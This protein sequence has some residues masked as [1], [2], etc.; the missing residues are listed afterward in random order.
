M[1]AAAIVVAAFAAAIVVA[2][3]AAA[4]V[5]A[6]FAFAAAAAITRY[7]HRRDPPGWWGRRIGRT[8]WRRANLPA[9]G[10]LMVALALVFPAIAWLL[11]IAA[12][13]MSAA[14][15]AGRIVDPLPPL[16]ARRR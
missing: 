16:T 1:V 4:I 5:V 7:E 15:I 9:G 10:T 13:W 6:A 11:L 8:R 2:A 12:V 3:F 14:A